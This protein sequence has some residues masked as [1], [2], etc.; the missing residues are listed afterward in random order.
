MDKST[1][2]AIYML[3]LITTCK[4]PKYARTFFPLKSH[5]EIDLNGIMY[6]SNI[7]EYIEYCDQIYNRN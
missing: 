3:M 5:V 4:V 6:Y 1:E 7:N 2:K